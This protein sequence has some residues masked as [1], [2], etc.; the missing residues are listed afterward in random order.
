MLFVRHEIVAAKKT[1]YN[2]FKKFTGK[3]PQEINNLLK[4]IL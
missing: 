4:F 3:N 2:N 1:F